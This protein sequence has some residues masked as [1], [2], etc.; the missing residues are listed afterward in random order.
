M[1][2]D[3]LDFIYFVWCIKEYLFFCL[4]FSGVCKVEDIV[5]GLFFF[6]VDVFFDGFDVFFVFLKILGEFSYD[7]EMF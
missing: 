5:D 2:Y 7:L 6:F 3:R 4:D 1:C